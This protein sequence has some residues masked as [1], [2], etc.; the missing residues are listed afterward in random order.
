[1]CPLMIAPNIRKKCVRKLENGVRST[2]F[3]ND[4]VDLSLGLGDVMEGQ[5]LNKGSRY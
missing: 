2:S 4:I 5:S 1:M 3:M